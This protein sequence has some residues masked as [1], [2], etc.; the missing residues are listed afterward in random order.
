M[1]GIWLLDH[2]EGVVLP[3]IRPNFQI[4]NL[5]AYLGRLRETFADLFRVFQAESFGSSFETL[6]LKLPKREL[7]QNTSA[8]RSSE[9]QQVLSESVS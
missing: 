2:S 7:A 5:S 3:I 9:K 6:K 4:I 8:A 1:T